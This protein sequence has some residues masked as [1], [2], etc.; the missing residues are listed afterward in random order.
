MGGVEG[1]PSSV[2]FRA[3]RRSMPLPAAAPH[4]NPQ[5]IWLAR[6]APAT[7]C[8]VRRR[9]GGP[10]TPPMIVSTAPQTS[11]KASSPRSAQDDKKCWGTALAL[12]IT[13]PIPRPCNQF[14]RPFVPSPTTQCSSRGLT[15][16]S[17]RNSTGRSAN[18]RKMNH[19][20]THF[21]HHCAREHRA[22]G[23]GQPAQIP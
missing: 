8:P 14:D 20:Q 7:T 17:T 2:G 3:E 4:E 18:H 11:R 13:L 12:E 19:D 9:L 22:T 16:L 5:D 10:L 23:T 15:L 21:P 6:K 1:P